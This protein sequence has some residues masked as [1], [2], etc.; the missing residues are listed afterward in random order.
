MKFFHKLWTALVNFLLIILPVILLSQLLYFYRNPIANK[1]KNF[2]GNP[3]TEIISTTKSLKKQ[4]LTPRRLKQL[5][6]FLD[7]LESR[8]EINEADQKRVQKALFQTHH[9]VVK[10][11]EATARSR[12]SEALN[13]AYSNLLETPLLTRIFPYPSRARNELISD[14]KRLQPL[15]KLPSHPAA[16]INKY[17]QFSDSVAQTIITYGQIYGD[18]L[19]CQ[20]MFNARCGQI[21]SSSVRMAAGHLR[22]YFVTWP[23]FGTGN[24][25][26]I[27]RFADNYPGFTKTLDRLGKKIRGYLKAQPWQKQSKLLQ[28]QEK[29]RQRFINNLQMSYKKVLENLSLVPEDFTTTSFADVT[30]KLKSLTQL[31][32]RLRQSSRDQALLLTQANRKIRQKLK[33]N[34]QEI[35]HWLT[36]KIKFDRDF[37]PGKNK[38]RALNNVLRALP[39][40]TNFI[41]S[42]NQLIDRIADTFQRLNTL[43]SQKNYAGLRNKLTELDKEKLENMGKAGWAI[44]L[45]SFLTNNRHRFRASD[46]QPLG[47]EEQQPY[48]RLI[49][50]VGKLGEKYQ[51]KQIN[52]NWVQETIATL[53]SRRFTQL[54]EKIT[55]RLSN[56]EIQINSELVQLVGKLDKLEELPPP[57]TGKPR[58]LMIRAIFCEKIRTGGKELYRQYKAV[59]ESNDFNQ[60][61]KE[62]TKIIAFINSTSPLD[63]LRGKQL[64]EFTNRARTW[65]NQNGERDRPVNLA[66]KF[67]RKKLRGFYSE[68]ISTFKY[69]ALNPK[70]SKLNTLRLLEIQS[71]LNK[72]L[73]AL[74]RNNGLQFD[75][76]T[77]KYRHLL[78][79]RQ[80]LASLDSLTEKLS[81]GSLFGQNEQ[82]SRFEKLTAPIEL[83]DFPAGYTGQFETSKFVRLHNRVVER[84]QEI[85]KKSS[86]DWLSGWGGRITGREILT[87]WMVFLE[88]LSNS[89]IPAKMKNKVKQGQK[90][91]RELKKKWSQ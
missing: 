49:K 89:Q 67:F 72:S 5:R 20:N 8:K 61:W 58:E 53:K 10:Q 4:Q 15:N 25:M 83:G 59:V 21:Y 76:D 39:G 57:L 14:F 87:E 11:L 73:A 13:S 81:G 12:Q 48:V 34:L 90:I 3:I 28:A 44:M 19:N 40:G 31:E 74:G 86:E 46:W 91:S 78:R 51:L 24:Q 37:E 77:E 69:Q 45:K 18:Q 27:V 65:L 55:S 35:Y 70:Q 9:A 47:D 66:N 52:N 88:S 85:R 1:F 84:A 43:F 23:D 26:N 82:F 42:E 56:S 32:K 60:R 63:A 2:L 36:A 80:R 62:L 17:M 6:N 54:Q 68:L 71:R 30:E 38:L 41:T 64:T 7:Q 75:L 50:Q 16:G 33:N 22:Q 79:L 29:F